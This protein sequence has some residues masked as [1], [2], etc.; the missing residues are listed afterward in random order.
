[1]LPEIET[2]RLTLRLARPGMQAQMARFLTANFPGHLD[3][4]FPPV[5]DAYFTEEYWRVRLGAWVEDYSADRAARFV[6]QLR[7]RDGVAPPIDAP[8]V[9]SCSYTNFVRGAF[10]A[11]HL[12]YQVGREFEGRGLMAE[13][14]R[15]CN[16]FVFGP[17]RMHRIMANFRPENL[18]SRALLQRLGFAEE[19]LAR[20]FLF[21]DGAWRDHVL[22]ALVNPEYDDA[23]VL[24]PRP[25]R[26][27]P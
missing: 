13:A 7:P 15:A 20:E 9:G 22:T 25:S 5:A 23:W 24:A 16:A 18:R 4:W 11:C 2:G 10:H 8:L 14:L 19:G 21:I 17:L 27:Q 1:M 6:M 3:R 26:S 12:G